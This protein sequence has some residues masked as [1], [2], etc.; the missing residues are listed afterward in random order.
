MGDIYMFPWVGPYQCCSCGEVS[1][2]IQSCV[3]IQF[4]IENACNM[5]ITLCP[6]CARVYSKDLSRSAD[7]AILSMKGGEQE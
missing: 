2:F 5:M 1:T 3:K 4:K 6:N 7:V